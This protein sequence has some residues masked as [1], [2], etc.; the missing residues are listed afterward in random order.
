ML[1]DECVQALENDAADTRQPA[2]YHY[3]SSALRFHLSISVRHIDMQHTS[4][5]TLVEHKENPELCPC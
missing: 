2:A 5:L 4:P 3:Y 1:T